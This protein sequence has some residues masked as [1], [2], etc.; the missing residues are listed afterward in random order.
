MLNSSTMFKNLENKDAAEASWA[1]LQLL[2]TISRNSRN[3][4]RKLHHEIAPNTIPES[5]LPVEPQKV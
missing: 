1:E 4:I 2:W 3:R 5:I